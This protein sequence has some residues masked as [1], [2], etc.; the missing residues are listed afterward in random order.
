MFKIENETDLHCKVV[1]YFR[2]F[3]PEAIIIAGLGDNQDTATKRINSSKKGYMRGQPD[4]I[5]A[6]QLEKHTGL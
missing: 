3:Y 2:S 6:N 1:E 4:I 5:I